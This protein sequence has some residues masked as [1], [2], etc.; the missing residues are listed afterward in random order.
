MAE[1]LEVKQLGKVKAGTWILV[2][3][4]VM[5]PSVIK[6]QSLKKRH[7][8]IRVVSRQMVPSHSL[9]FHSQS[10]AL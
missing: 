5:L 9:F 7:F 3:G 6:F 2:W 10:Q 4:T 8:V 1:H